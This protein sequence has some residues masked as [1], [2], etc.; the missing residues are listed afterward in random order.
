MMREAMDES[1]MATLREIQDRERALSARQPEGPSYT[2]YCAFCG[3]DLPSPR[4]WCD[5]DCRDAWERET[6]ARGRS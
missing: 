2:G 1:D 5:A 6:G 3:E 4:R